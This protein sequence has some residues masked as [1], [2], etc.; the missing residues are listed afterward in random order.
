MNSREFVE[1]LKRFNQETLSRMEA[2]E[3][4]GTRVDVLVLLRIAL[5]NEPE[6]WELAAHWMPLTPELEVKLGL[7][8][9]VGGEAKH[10]DLLAKR[11]SHCGGHPG[12]D[13][14]RS[15][16]ARGQGGPCGAHRSA[17]RASRHVHAR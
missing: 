4:S 5:K 3:R 6:A 16:A 7:V 14:R 1:E 12:K 8:R 13:A 15:A 11:Q 10:Y 2:D 9:Q 17:P